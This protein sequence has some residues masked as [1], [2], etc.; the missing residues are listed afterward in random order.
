MEHVD[1]EMALHLVEFNPSPVCT[2]EKMPSPHQQRLLWRHSSVSA[3]HVDN[4]KAHNLSHFGLSLDQ[5][6]WLPA[7]FVGSMLDGIATM[8]HYS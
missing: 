5:M 2:R 1:D 3:R 7:V 6:A 4:A 8:L